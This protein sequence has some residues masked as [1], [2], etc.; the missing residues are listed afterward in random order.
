MGLRADA[1]NAEQ[2]SA[3][4]PALSLFA[5]SRPSG[6]ARAIHPYNDAVQRTETDRAGLFEAGVSHRRSIL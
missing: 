6:H 5:I 1:A 2:N 3:Y 4:R